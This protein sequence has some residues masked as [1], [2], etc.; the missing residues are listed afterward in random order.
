MRLIAFGDSHTYG[1]ELPGGSGSGHAGNFG[2]T[3]PSPVAWPQLVANHLDCECVN[4]AQPG[5]SNKEILMRVLKFQFQ[6]MDH[7]IILWT[8]VSRDIIFTHNGNDVKVSASRLNENPKVKY[9]YMA[10]GDHDMQVSAW[11][12]MDHAASHLQ[13]QNIKFGMATYDTWNA[14]SRVGK[15]HINI[16]KTFQDLG[17]DF[18]PDNAHFGVQSHVSL[19]KQM[20]S[21]LGW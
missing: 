18:L 10:H 4:I 7:V 12:C 19:S 15:N 5:Y 3:E 20:I 2:Y 6:P 8:H 16:N 11:L 13:L 9:Y 14:G 21:D 1:G 17:T